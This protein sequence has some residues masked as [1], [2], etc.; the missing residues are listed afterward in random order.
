V[1]DGELVATVE[2]ADREEQLD[3]RLGYDVDGN[4]WSSCDRGDAPGICL[5]GLAV[6]L[7]YGTAAD[8]D[9]RLNMPWWWSSRKRAKRSCTEVRVE[10][11]SGEPWSGTWRARSVAAAG[12]HFQTAY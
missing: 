3:L 12:S 11:L 9:G 8:A 10:S 4:L 2:D 5:H 1:V 6:L 7:A